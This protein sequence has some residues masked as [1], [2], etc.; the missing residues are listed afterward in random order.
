ML[1]GAYLLII[2]IKAVV[3]GEIGK[4]GWIDFKPGWYVYVGSAM[5]GLEA[6]VKRHLSSKKRKHWHIDYLLGLGSK[7]R[8]EQ[9]VIVTSTKKIE[10]EL[11]KL[12]AGLATFSVARFGSSD[13]KCGSHLYY[14]P[15]EQSIRGLLGAIKRA[16]PN[17]TIKE[18][19]S[20]CLDLARN[21]QLASPT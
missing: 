2:N 19:Q 8:V 12:V 10:C 20:V 5:G 16:K 14:F 9:V 6:R 21:R 3:K 15:N 18:A 13:C 4:L 17:V 7:V 11:S 1:C